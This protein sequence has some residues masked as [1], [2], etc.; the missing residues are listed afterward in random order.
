MPAIADPYAGRPF[1]AASDTRDHGHS[2]RARVGAALHRGELSCALAEGA[3]PGAS[4]ERAVGAAQLTGER[5]RR[6]LAH[7]MRRTLADAHTP[8]MTRPRAVSIRRGAVLDAED[9]INVMMERLG[10]PAPLQ[11]EG[12]ALAERILTNVDDSPLY[13]SS[14]PGSLRRQITVAKAAPEPGH[15]PSHEFPVGVR[16]NCA[17][18]PTSRRTGELRPP[19]GGD[20]GPRAGGPRLATS[21]THPAAR[22]GQGD[23]RGAQP[24]W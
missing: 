2:L 18:P 19:P 12:M 9:A 5:S 17:Q 6:S 8:A 3:N 10:S 13:N 20:P 11:A 16:P 14:S 7:A 24:R 23:R 21:R 1:D 22:P 4:D 15:S